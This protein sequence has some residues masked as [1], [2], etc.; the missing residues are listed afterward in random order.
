MAWLTQEQLV[1]LPEL[2]GGPGADG[3][4]ATSVQVEPS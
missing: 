3:A 2:D 1:N 4:Q